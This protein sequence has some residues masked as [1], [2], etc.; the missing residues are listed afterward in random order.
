ME[1]SSQFQ[2]PLRTIQNHGNIQISNSM[3]SSPQRQKAKRGRPR[4]K[5]GRK[6]SK[7]SRKK[8][9]QIKIQSNQYHKKNTITNELVTQIQKN[10]KKVKRKETR[11]NKEIEKLKQELKHKNI[12]IQSQENNMNLS[13]IYNQ[14]LFE[15]E[16]KSKNSK[17]RMKKKLLLANKENVKLLLEN[18]ENADSDDDEEYLDVIAKTKDSK[19]CIIDDDDDGQLFGNQKESKYKYKRYSLNVV[20]LT[21]YLSTQMGLEA[22]PNVIKYTLKTY[23]TKGNTKIPSCTTIRKWLSY[24]GNT[25]NIENIKY[26]IQ[27]QQLLQETSCFHHDGSSLGSIQ[28]S[29]M[30]ISYKK[31]KNILNH[32]TKTIDEDKDIELEKDSDNDHEIEI[33]INGKQTKKISLKSSEIYKFEI[34]PL[35]LQKLKGIQS[36][37][38]IHGSEMEIPNISAISIKIISIYLQKF[39]HKAPKQPKKDTTTLHT[40]LGNELFEFFKLKL[41][42]LIKLWNDTAYLGFYDLFNLLQTI[43]LAKLDTNSIIEH[44]ENGTELEFDYDADNVLNYVYNDY[45]YQLSGFALSAKHKKREHIYLNNAKLD[46]KTAEN[47]G[48]EIKSTLCQFDPEFIKTISASIKDQAANENKSILTGFDLIKLHNDILDNNAFKTKDNL[49]IFNLFCAA[50]ILNGSGEG[51]HNQICKFY[52]NETQKKYKKKPIYL[53]QDLQKFI[54]SKYNDNNNVFYAKTTEFRGWIKYKQSKDPT[55]KD[56]KKSL[57]SEF[58]ETRISYAFSHCFKALK[59]SQTTRIYKFNQ[60]Q[61]SK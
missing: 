42:I 36:N 46:A 43:I 55:F 25:I 60:K 18:E 37:A 33:K 19:I 4:K 30:L 26:L 7:L 1:L 28:Y 10:R 52:N 57:K 39:Q 24:Y 51:Y 31:I 13:C 38:N 27:N 3:T 61:N 40:Y 15:K 35:L 21:L 58:P 47:I 14:R 6:V 32:N 29:S 22:I 5:R 56:P 59:A 41:R 11:K 23:K 53:I 9:S 2:S 17:D 48:K 49:D 12:Y 45:F 54:I 44:I 16:L 50:H 34:H 8:Q 20:I